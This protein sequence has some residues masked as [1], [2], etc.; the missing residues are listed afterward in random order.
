MPLKK[1]PTNGQTY[2]FLLE[3]YSLCGQ[4]EKA[5]AVAEKMMAENLLSGIGGYNSV[6]R[7]YIRAKRFQEALD[8]HDSLVCGQGPDPNHT[9]YAVLIEC[10]GS[11]A[12][13]NK[14]LISALQA[15]DVDLSPKVVL[16]SA[17]L[18]ALGR[19]SRSEDAVSIF[20][21]LKMF[22]FP[23]ALAEL[24]LLDDVGEHD[25]RW[26]RLAEEFQRVDN[27]G[28]NAEMQRGFHNAFVDAL[29]I[30]GWEVRALRVVEF[31]LERGI[32][33]NV[34]T[35]DDGEWRLQLQMTSVGAAQ[36]LLLT[37]IAQI[38]AE[39]QKGVRIADIIRIV[40]AAEWQ[41]LVQD[42]L[43]ARQAVVAQLKDL[44]APFA[45]L[46]QDTCEFQT[47]GRDFLEWLSEA[48]SADS[49][50]LSNSAASD[51]EMEELR[52][53]ALRCFHE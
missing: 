6:L 44:K 34:C 4:F 28:L 36:V 18:E 22:G 50:F 45:S 33:G 9:S 30:L 12:A 32:F 51:S 29:W 15:I 49:L 13:V 1:L 2:S 21:S 46:H 17:L 26:Q 39:V 11:D 7:Y 3:A 14:R 23:T 43:A 37:W 20:G 25:E 38:Q 31:S 42:N 5:A 19:C 53:Q 10:W 35:W 47:T 40:L 52:K 27:E 48:R 24:L 16:F 8:L 41:V